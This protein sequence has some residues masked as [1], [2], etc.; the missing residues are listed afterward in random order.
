MSEGR[1]TSPRSNAFIFGAVQD[2]SP[3]E[4]LAC[5]VWDISPEGAMIE[6][7]DLDTVPD[8]FSL[9]LPGEEAPRAA[10]VVWRA[11]RRLGLSV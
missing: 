4:P 1:R 11:G 7:S 5:M 6:V 2:G 3:D 8:T 10:T 9:A